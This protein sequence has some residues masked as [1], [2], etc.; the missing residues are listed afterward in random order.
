MFV[1][2]S[3][4]IDSR[5]DTFVKSNNHRSVVGVYATLSIPYTDNNGEIHDCMV[6]PLLYNKEYHGEDLSAYNAES[7]KNTP[8]SSVTV[9]YPIDYKGLVAYAKSKGMQPCELEQSEKEK[10]IMK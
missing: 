1:S 8:E 6:I 5:H 9:L 2:N 10:F 4:K 3:F 7:L